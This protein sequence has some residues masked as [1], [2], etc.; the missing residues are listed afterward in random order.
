MNNQPDSAPGHRFSPR[1]VFFSAWLLVSMLT[2][3]WSLATPISGSPDEPAHIIKAAAVVRG[4]L[5]GKTVEGGQLVTVPAYVAYTQS[6][7][8]FSHRVNTTA[9]CATPL[10]SDPWHEVAV[11]T[12]AGLYNPTYY[13]LVGWP[14]LIFHNEAGIYAMRLV[15]GVITSL[16]LALSV[17][18]LSRWRRP[19]ITL[20]GFATAVSPMML[21]LGGAVNPSSLE[22]TATLASFVGVLS[23]VMRP[24]ARALRARSAL[25]LV[26]AALAV[27]TRGIS[28][29]WVGLAVLLP[30]V[31]A[32]RP[33]LRSL[34][35]SKSVKLAAGA[36]VAAVALSL[37]WTRLSN[38]LGA[39]LSTQGHVVT[40]Q[41]V[42]ASPLNGFTQIFLGTFDYGEGMI[43]VFGWLDTPAPAY[44]F[45]AWSTLIGAIAL[46]GFSV[47]RGRALGLSIALLGLLLLLPPL[48]Q[49]I[50]IT[51][52]GIIWQGRY[53]LP[54]YTCLVVALCCFLAEQL[55][56]MSKSFLRRFSI[57]CGFLWA[58]AQIAAFVLTLK[59]Y[60]V[61]THGIAWADF[62]THPAWAPPGGVSLMVAAFIV[63]AACAA[64]AVSRASFSAREPKLPASS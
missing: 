10:T 13:F 59:R 34:I 15:S 17:T 7:T 54:L 20:I 27:N 43:G 63:V 23:V 58:S 57:L 38:S 4:E 26:S 6:Q 61:G 19:A 49:A 2:A 25:V 55:P 9:N 11:A 8:C 3:L 21:F 31:L 33:Q 29:L 46:V 51:G 42:G 1:L 45:F 60:S 37:V 53:A 64:G 18:L 35:T 56:P 41:G 28:P 24:D 32:T 14:S 36:V 62:F 39:G 16:F 22:A 50:Y 30:L 44:T 12:S 48:L 47:I 52:G 40:G 5:L